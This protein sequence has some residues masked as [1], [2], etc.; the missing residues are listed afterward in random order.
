MRL[1]SCQ[2]RAERTADFAALRG[3]PDPAPLWTILDLTPE[4][5]GADWYPKL[6]YDR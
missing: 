2:F 4:G 3:A 1:D 5:R 6:S